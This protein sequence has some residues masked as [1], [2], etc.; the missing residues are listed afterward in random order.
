MT[1]RMF[2]TPVDEHE[3]AFEAET[4]TGMRHGAV[5]TQV[6]IPFVIGRIHFVAAHVFF[7]NFATFFA[8]T[9]ADDLADSGN[10]HVHRGDRFAVIV[11]AHVER[12]YFLWIIEDRHRRFEM[13]LRQ[14]ALVFRLQIC[15]VLDRELEF[16]AALFQKLNRFGVADALER[17]LEHEIKARDQFLVDK[18][19]EELEF[20]RTIFSNVA[21][22]IFH[23][24]F[25]DVHVALQIAERHFGF[26]HPKFVGMT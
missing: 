12:F 14:P 1:S 18:L 25:R 21:N 10:E 7:E 17:S 16:L 9:T 23:D 8:L 26:D 13:F 5:T 22:Q 3:H 19:R 24:L 2:E 4:E 11:H 20:V 6:E 15:A